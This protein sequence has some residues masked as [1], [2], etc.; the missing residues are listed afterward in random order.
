MVASLF[1]YDLTDADA[2]RPLYRL[3]HT[4]KVGKMVAVPTF[5]QFHKMFV[6]NNFKLQ[7]SF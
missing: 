1:A 6:K 3:L 4:S 5:V 2:Y 7:Y